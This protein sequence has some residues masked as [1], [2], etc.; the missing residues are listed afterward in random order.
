MPIVTVQ[1]VTH[2]S[3]RWPDTTVQKLSDALGDLFQTGPGTTWLRIEYLPRQQ[4]AENRV[5]LDD[6]LEPTFVEVLRRSLPRNDIL[7]KEAQQIAVLTG[8][9]LSRPAENVHVIYLPESSG[10]IAFGGKL[11]SE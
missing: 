5:D 9:I 1:C 10:R 6:D 3:E 11:I 7:A 2:S 8:R 4:Y